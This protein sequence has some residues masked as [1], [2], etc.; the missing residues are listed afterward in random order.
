MIFS[1]HYLSWR[2]E[3]KFHIMA[4]KPVYE[5]LK[6][7]LGGYK[8]H[9]TCTCDSNEHLIDLADTIGPIATDGLRNGL[10][11]L[12]ERVAK[13]DAQIE[14]MLTVCPAKD[15][16]AVEALREPIHK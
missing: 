2:R 10:V 5:D 12:D 1:T 4:A 9:L 7:S 6:R 13:C 15:Y 14:L 11:V 16:D 3:R 8:A